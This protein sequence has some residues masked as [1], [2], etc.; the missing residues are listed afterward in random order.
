MA[1]TGV[2]QY[3]VRQATLGG[4]VRWLAGVPCPVSTRCINLPSS[5][6]QR[7]T[8]SV[9]PPASA[10]L[11]QQQQFLLPPCGLAHEDVMVLAF[12]GW[13]D[14]ATT[15]TLCGGQGFGVE[16]AWVHLNFESQRPPSQQADGSGPR[17]KG[18][19]HTQVSSALRC[20]VRPGC[21]WLPSPHQTAACP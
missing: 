18:L 12:S 8:E 14:S 21:R 17:V 20:G 1:S 5:H 15:C 10:S 4:G 7:Q 11:G 2:N 6:P 13:M 9:Q 16:D 3:M 19:T